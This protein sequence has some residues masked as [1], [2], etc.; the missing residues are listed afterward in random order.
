MVSEDEAK[1]YIELSLHEC[2]REQCIPEK[3][4]H[5]TPKEYHLFH[6][7]TNGKGT[8]TLAGVTYKIHKGM[9]FYIPP[10]AEP[11]YSPDAADPW[12]YE[13]LGF[14]G[15]NASRFLSLSGI[16]ETSP[17]YDDSNMALKP[18]FDEIVNEYS[19]KGTLDL[20]CLSQAYAIFSKMIQNGDKAKANLSAKEGHL[21]S[22]KE[23]ILNNYEFDIKV[24]DVAS[25]VG[26]SANYLAS[27]FKELEDSS[28]KNYLT[29]IRMEKAKL[30]LMTGRYKIKE[31]AEM[32]GYKN[33][34]HFSSQFHK[35]YSKAPSDY[36]GQKE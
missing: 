6:Y 7:V 8:F 33:Q 12:S 17:V 5:F 21:I 36:L 25:N 24:E 29:Q 4:F 14:A 20:Y 32:V 23:Y 10:R 27:V 26:V 1:N 13:W 19:L 2:G 3:I 34:L 9:I 16:S 22:A 11:H 35:Y 28:T 30:L 31:V 15:S 18:F